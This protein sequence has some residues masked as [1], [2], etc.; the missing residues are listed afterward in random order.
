MSEN[1][2]RETVADIIREKRKMAAEIRAHLSIVPARREEQLLEADSLDRE[3]DRIEAAAKRD[4]DHAVEHATRHAEAVARDNCRDCVH[5]PR[6]KNYE[7]GNAAA[8]REACQ[9]TRDLLVRRGD[10]KVRCVLTWDEFNYAQ[11]MLRAA[12]AAPPRNCDAGTPEEQGE[13]CLAQFEQWRRKGDGKKLITAI[14]TWAQM[15]Y[16]A[17][18][19]G[20]K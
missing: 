7:G 4:E 10:G 18:E 17:E 12:L 19:G 16:K 9:K 2:S 8:M 15:P 6:G 3:A 1:E 11:K 20:A 14:M 13:R 5:N